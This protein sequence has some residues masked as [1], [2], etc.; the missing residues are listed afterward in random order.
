MQGLVPQW[1]SL[2]DGKDGLDGEQGSVGV[3]ELKVSYTDTQ[4][5]RT[6]RMQD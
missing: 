1:G 6:P 3:V 5:E 2:Y 4:P